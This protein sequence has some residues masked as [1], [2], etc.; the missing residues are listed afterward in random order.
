MMK[1]ITTILLSIASV[2]ALADKYGVDESMSEGEASWGEVALTLI[3][4]A[5]LYFKGK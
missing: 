4:L 5:Y 1:Q 2:S 3:V